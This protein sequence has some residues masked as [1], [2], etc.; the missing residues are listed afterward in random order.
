MWELGL[1]GRFWTGGKRPLLENYF[2]RVKLRDSFKR[3]IP[4]LPFHLKM[5]IMSQP[6]SYI[7]AAGVASIGAVAVL[8]YAFKRLI[9]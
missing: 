8:V 5:I 7:G 6:P 4:N 3:T 2:S 1:E 9:F